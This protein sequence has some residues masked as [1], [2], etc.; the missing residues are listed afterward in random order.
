MPV[1]A[2]MLAIALGGCAS[3]APPMPAPAP[4][5]AEQRTDVAAALA[6]ERQW[7]AQWFRG[8]PVLVAQRDDGAVTVDVPRE[9]CFEPRSSTP[10]P[11][12]AAVLDKLAESLR[13]VPQAGLTLLAA[14]DDAGGTGALALQRAARM[15]DHLRGRGVAGAR[16]GKPA[17]TAAAAV[18]LR[19]QAA[20]P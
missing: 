16:L 4:V 2:L 20:V 17:A 8:T 5:T 18:Q 15:Q 12:L 14:P 1:V 13:R 9:F 19:V 7:L 3:V 11:A 6:V 10:K